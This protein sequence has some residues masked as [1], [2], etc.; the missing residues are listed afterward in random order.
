M[1]LGVEQI[2]QVNFINWLAYAYPEVR[3]HVI[4]IGN[5]GKRSI[6]GHK[7]AKKM[8][9][10]KFASDL[11]IAYPCGGFHGAFIEIKKDGWKPTPSNKIHTEGQLCFIDK[12]K[13]AG[14]FAEMCVGIDR[15]IFVV[16]EYLSL[17]K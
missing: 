7:I 5:E 9:L 17:D 16:D 10:H 11:F 8:G 13:L 1:Q 2:V 4:M 12:M 6:Q 3:K 15:C 14:Y